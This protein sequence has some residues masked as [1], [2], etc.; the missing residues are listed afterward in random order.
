[1]L[2][3]LKSLLSGPSCAEDP[4]ARTVSCPQI[5]HGRR[6][7]PSASYTS[8]DTNHSYIPDCSHCIAQ[9]TRTLQSHFHLLRSPTTGFHCLP[10][11]I[12][13]CSVSSAP[14]IQFAAIIVWV[15][16]VGVCTTKTMIL[17]RQYDDSAVYTAFTRQF[18][19]E[20]TF[21]AYR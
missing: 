7:S 1:M 12:A 15:Y 6:A 9:S 3:F 11:N 17:D 5:Y 19:P 8:Q 4:F 14:F 2:L 10:A 13:F 21:L 16:H 18:I 20:T